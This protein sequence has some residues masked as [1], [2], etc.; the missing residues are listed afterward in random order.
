MSF[1]EF[2]IDKHIILP[3]GHV[4]RDILYPWF[5]IPLQ[6]DVWIIVPDRVEIVWIR[7]CPSPNYLYSGT[8]QQ[9]IVMSDGADSIRGTNQRKAQNS[10]LSLPQR[11]DYNAR[12]DP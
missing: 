2:Y 3:Q 7:H 4:N 5:C 11:V 8:E 12:H 9:T 1:I 6:F 10:Q